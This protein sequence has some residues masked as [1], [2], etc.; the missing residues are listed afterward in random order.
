MPFSPKNTTN[1]TF[2][3]DRLIRAFWSRRLFPHPLRWLHLGFNIIPL[4]PPLISC[5]DVLK[6][7]FITICIGEH[8][9]TDF[10]MVLFLIVSQQTW[11]EFCTDTMHLKFFS[12]NLMAR[13][14]ADPHFVSNFLKWQFPWITGWTLSTRLLFVGVES[15]PGLGSSPTNI[16]PSLKCLN[17]S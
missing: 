2:I 9:L 3:F 4:N 14:Y 10:N 13:S 7:V 6:K 5:C 12:K 15:H 16:L 11:H 1:I 8:S 17:L